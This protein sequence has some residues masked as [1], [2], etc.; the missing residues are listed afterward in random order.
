MPAYISLI[1]DTDQG[2]RNIKDSPK[3]P[4]PA[5]KALKDLGGEL[6]DFYVTMGG[7]DIVVI[8]EAPSDEA[9]AKF[10][11]ASGSLGNVR[12]TTLNAFPEAEH[13]KIIKAL[14]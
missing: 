8:A 1:N 13:R 12:T 10:L 7:Y 9:I 2:I 14:P 3:R 6:K 4:D 5:K 11:L